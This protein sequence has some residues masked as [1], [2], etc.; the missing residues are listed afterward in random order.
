[1]N[2]H[3]FTFSIYYYIY[4]L[5]F[6]HAARHHTRKYHAARDIALSASN[7]IRL[8]TLLYMG[9]LITCF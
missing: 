6:Y 5:S 3:H 7:I 1:M 2:V 4:N 8:F 9:L